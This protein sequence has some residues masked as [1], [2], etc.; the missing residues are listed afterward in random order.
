MLDS[1]RNFRLFL[2]PEFSFPLL[3]FDELCVRWGKRE[4]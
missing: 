3:I 2:S 4:K 1:G